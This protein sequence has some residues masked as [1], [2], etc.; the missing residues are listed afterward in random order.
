[1]GNS[2]FSYIQQLEVLVFFSGYPLVFVV[3]RFLARQHIIEKFPGRGDLCSILPFAYA[4]IGTL[5]V[6]YQLMNLYPDYTI[7]NVR[8]RIQ[9]PYLII[10]ALLSLLFWIPAISKKQI[11]SVLHSLVFFF[12]IVRDLFFQLTGYT[13]DRNILR[14]DMKIYTMSV[15]L[16]LAA[17]I[18]VVVISF[19]PFFRKKYPKT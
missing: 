11:L 1:M 8:H 4:L 2:I 7:E 15:F 10:W 6:C 18:L 3:V 19:L 5:Y 13:S 16:N 9:Q 14:N 12:I 17:V